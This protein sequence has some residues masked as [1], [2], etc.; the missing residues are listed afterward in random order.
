MNKSVIKYLLT[1][2][3]LSQT[4]IYADSI[5]P[6]VPTDDGGWGG[7]VQAG[8]VVN[9]GNSDNTNLNGKVTAHY[10]KN[11]WHLNSSLEG[12]L[13]SSDEN[14]T[15]ENVTFNTEG[16]YAFTSRDYLFAKGS[17]VY[18]KFAT[19]D[20]VFQEA[21]GYGRVLYRDKKTLLTIE[22]GP[23]GRHSR[24]LGTRTYQ[25]EFI[26]NVDGTFKRQL[27]ENT[28]FIQTA[29][30]DIGKKNTRTKSV[31]AL[32]TKMSKNL[33][34]QLSYTVQHDSQASNVPGTKKTD[35]ISK[36]AVVYD[37]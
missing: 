7:S 24:L 32:K 11:Q 12:E 15:A 9:R 27:T 29:A 37:F 16:R 3:L 18:D 4:I 2:L 17:I 28:H 35:T 30:I 21:I 19:F 26:L 6:N 13:N 5:H 1:L 8:G 20:R 31:S 10:H 14:T 36:V 33:A 23:G 34:L 22:S 25:N